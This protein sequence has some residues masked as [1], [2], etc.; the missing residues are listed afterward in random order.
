MFIEYQLSNSMKQNVLEKAIVAQVV[1]ISAAFNRNRKFI[2][3]F[4]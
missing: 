3:V 1:K 4:T 2:A